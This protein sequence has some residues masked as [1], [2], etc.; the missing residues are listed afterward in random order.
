MI[1]AAHNETHLAEIRNDFPNITTLVC[2]LSDSNSV[3]ELINT[4]SLHHRDLNVLINNAGIQYN[5]SWIN[6]KDGFTKMS[7]EIR[8]NFTSPMQ[9]AYGLLPLLLQQKNSAIVNVSSGLALAPK[10]TAPIYCG[11]KSAIH[12]ATKALRY[13]LENS[14]VKVFEIIPPPVDTAMNEGDKKGKI[15]AQRV[16]NEFLKNF[17]NNQLES[18]IG[19]IKWFRLIQRLSPALADRMKKNDL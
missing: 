15:S 8:V 2:D 14:S 19:K 7:T 16:V 5:Y 1:V 4:F 12:T 13:Q 11:T 17:Q 3:R 6:E 18:N 9:I 10:K